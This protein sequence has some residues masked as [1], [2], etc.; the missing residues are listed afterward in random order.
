MKRIHWLILLLF[1]FLWFLYWEPSYWNNNGYNLSADPGN[2][3][4][5]SLT[6]PKSFVMVDF[7]SKIGGNDKYII[8]ESNN[9]IEIKYWIIEKDSEKKRIEGPLSLEEFK[10]RKKHLF[11]DKL[12]F[13]KEFDK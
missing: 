3:G 2:P 7:V 12:K 10:N 8:V 4:E 13:E 5:L 1:G 6:N 9:D 11:I